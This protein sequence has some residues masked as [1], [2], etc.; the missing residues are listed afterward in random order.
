MHGIKETPRCQYG[1][2]FLLLDIFSPLDTILI[3]IEELQIKIH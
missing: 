3:D 2:K 1:L